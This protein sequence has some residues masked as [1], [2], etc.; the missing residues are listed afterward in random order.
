MCVCDV[1]TDGKQCYTNRLEEKFWGLVGYMVKMLKVIF[2]T[3]NNHFWR[4]GACATRSD[5]F[6]VVFFIHR[7]HGG[8]RKGVIC[9]AENK[10]Y[11]NLSC[12][13]TTL[14]VCNV[15][16]EVWL[17]YEKV[18]GLQWVRPPQGLRGPQKQ[19]K[20]G[21]VVWAS[22]KPKHIRLRHTLSIKARVYGYN[23]KFQWSKRRKKVGKCTK[24][25]DKW[26][27]S[28]WKKNK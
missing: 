17:Q 20:I 1:W 2:P 6:F 23:F 14:S 13:S 11:W 26:V 10:Y 8:G 4:T 24:T 27:K 5:Q 28:D 12:Y 7:W 3:Q 21:G 15:F 16:Q 19:A 18:W 9:M 22:K 25:W